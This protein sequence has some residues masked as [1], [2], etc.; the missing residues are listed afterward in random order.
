MKR[1]SLRPSV[2][3]AAALLLSPTLASAEVETSYS[4]DLA[5]AYVW[6]GITFLD[7]PS[8]QPSI[9]I[10]HS[11]GFNVNVWGTMDLNDDNG[12]QGEFQ[13]VDFT[14][15]YGFD[16]GLEIGLI[17][18]AFPGGGVDTKELYLGYGWDLPVSPSI[19]VYYD[20]DEV[21]DFYATFSLDYSAPI[22]GGDSTTF[23]VGIVVG[24]AGD[25][26]A[27]AYGGT[28]GG[29]FDGT[30]SLGVSHSLDGGWDFGAFVAYV[31][32]LDDDALVEQPVDVY[33]GIS[34]S[35]AF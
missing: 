34:F 30:L 5:S 25:D 31:D 15:S 22:G 24:Y 17:D 23:D 4:L 1:L 11:S 3:L 13:E 27:V 18:Y 32:S 33:G 2:V 6:R 26:F 35:K 8:F 28:D 21:E 9:N 29:F 16:N 20:F 7:G 12:L 19:T 14:L 10:A